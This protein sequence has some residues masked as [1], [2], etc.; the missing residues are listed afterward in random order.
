MKLSP[1][2]CLLGTSG[3]GDGVVVIGDTVEV[4]VGGDVGFGVVVVVVLGDGCG[5]LVVVVGFSVVVVVVVVEVVVVEDV[6]EVVVEGVVVDVEEVVVDFVVG[7]TDVVVLLS[8]GSGGR[9]YSF[10]S[11]SPKQV[12]N[13]SINKILLFRL[14]DVPLLDMIDEKNCPYWDN[15][16]EGAWKFF[17]ISVFTYVY[18]YLLCISGDLH[19]TSNVAF[20]KINT[21]NNFAQFIVYDIS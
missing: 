5:L 14:R 19:V 7:G 6:V 8:W 16:A 17:Y 20:I 4:E 9:W 2:K 21:L 10:D 15:Y 3:C 18:L 1:S 11:T 12:L 13:W